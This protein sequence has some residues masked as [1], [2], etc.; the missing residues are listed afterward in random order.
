MMLLLRN[1]IVD[2]ELEFSCN[3]APARLGIIFRVFENRRGRGYLDRRLALLTLLL[4]AAATI[5]FP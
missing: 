3:P 5:G 1:E 4:L 2:P